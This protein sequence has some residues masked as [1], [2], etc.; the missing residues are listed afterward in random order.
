MNEEFVVTNRRVIQVE[1]VVNK[2]VDRQLAR[3]DQRRG[4][5]PVDLR[6]DVRLRRPRHPDRGRER[7][8]TSIRMLREADDFKKAMLDAKHDLEVDMERSGWTP[9]PPLRPTP[10]CRSAMA[11]APRRRRRRRRGVPRRAAEPAAGAAA[12]SRPRRRH[13][14]AA[15][16]ADLRDRGAISAE[17]YEAQEGRPA[18]ALEQRHAAERRRTGRVR[19]VDGPE[20]CGRYVRTSTTECRW[21]HARRSSSSPSCCSS[22]SRST[23]SAHALA[24][25]RLGDGTAKLFGR[26]TLNPIAHFDPVGGTLLADVHRLGRDRAVRV[27]L[28]EADAGQPART[29]GG[30][31]GEAI[32]AAGRAALEPR[33]RR[34]RR[35]SRCAHARQPGA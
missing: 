22:R 30:R 12:A 21:I 34:R 2:T 6:A 13:P 18:R 29:W 17:E 7:R 16:L 11:G 26:L 9:G 8:S 31:R 4:A 19:W 28:G 1:G 3:E 25:Y 20:R 27:R 14:D 10:R 32:V 24:A 5:D 15:N 35:R 33:P 23:S